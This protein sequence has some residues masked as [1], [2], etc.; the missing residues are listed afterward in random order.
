MLMAQCNCSGDAKG[1]FQGGSFFFFFKGG[2]KKKASNSSAL[3]NECLC[4]CKLKG[5]NPVQ[6]VE[7]SRLKSS[8][9]TAC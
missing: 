8:S 5:K 3:E 7:L 9:C 4:L 6:K 1:F 2:G